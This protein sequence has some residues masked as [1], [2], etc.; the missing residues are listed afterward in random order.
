[1]R[2]PVSEYTDPQRLQLEIDTLFRQF[3]VI[4]GHRSELA[5]PGQFV[6]HDIAGVPLLITRGRDREVRAFINVCRHRGARLESEPCGKASTFSCP[7]HGW[8][9]G[10]D[11][12]LRGL[13]HASGFGEIN[14]QEFNLVEVP[15]FERFGLIWVRPSPGDAPIDIDAWLAPMAEQLTSLEL[16]EHVVFKRWSVPLAM[17][18]HIA[19]E[20]FQEQYHFC[21]AHKHTACAAYLDNQGVY[22]DQYPHVR[23]A[24]PVTGIEKLAEIAPA[25]RSYRA[26][27]MTQNY[28]FPCQF[29][30]VMTDHVYIHTIIPTGTNSCEFHCVMLIPESTDNEKAHKHWQANYDVVQ[31]VF[32]EDFAIGEGIQAGLATGVN[33]HFT[34]GR[35]EAGLQL[36]RKAL[37]DALTGRLTVP[38]AKV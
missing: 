30:Q 1:M 9:Y 27:F 23:H 20:G 16:S 19:L 3:P 5:E 35:F 22:L 13:R 32:A 26:H 33:D 4:I 14:K 29:A 18:W 17:N 7:Y 12:A 10:L 24:V 21:S 11:G 34:I 28:L 2:I 31:R 25:D 8:T 15:A 6:T 38:L 36:A 37:D